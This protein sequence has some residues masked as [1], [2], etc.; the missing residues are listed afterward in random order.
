MAYNDIPL[1]LRTFKQWVC[2]RYEEGDGGKPTK[3][4]YCAYNGRLAATDNP[5][6]WCTFDEAVYAQHQGWYAGIG[7]VLTDADP[8]TFI[9]LDDP[10]EKNSK[11]EFKHANPDEVLQRQI[12]LFN[13][14]KSYA[15]RSPSGTGLHIICKGRVPSG[16]RRS[17]IEVYSNLRFMTMTGDVYRN[18][19]I[20]DE[21]ELV[22]VLYN[23]MGEGRNAVAFYA[24]L[25]HATMTDEA[26]IEM[27]SNAANGEKFYDLFYVGNW[28]KYYPSQSEADFA[29]FDII[30]FYSK[31]G[32]QTQRIFLNSAIGQREK[33]RAQYRLNY[34]L[35]RCFDNML[36]PVDVDGLRNQIEEILEKKKQE[37]IENPAPVANEYTPQEIKTEKSIYSVPPGLVGQ[38]AQFIYAQAPRPVAEI[39]LAGALGFVAGIVGRAY[40]VSGTGLN[41]YI[42]LLAP[43]GTGKEAIAG[44]IDK[45][46]AYVCKS[47]PAAKDFIGP[48]KI[49]SE[50]ALLKYLSRSSV[51]FSSVVGEFGIRIRE[52][53]AHNAAPHMA[54]LLALLLDLFN[55]SGEGKV[56]HSS[57]YSDR[58]K[59]TGDILAPAVSITGESTPEKFYEILNESMIE[60]GMLPRW[61]IIEY[62]GDRPP[63]NENHMYAQPSFE[64]IEKLS[65]LCAHCLTLNSQHKAIHVQ[66]TPEAK[67]LFERFDKHCDLNINS[68][69][70][71]V[72]RH[73]WNRA[74][75]NSL[76]LAALVSTGCNPY[77][78]TIDLDIGNWAIDLIVA[79]VR[80]MLSRFDAGEI[81]ID[82]EETKQLS[83]LMQ[84]IKE[85]IL[86]PWSEVEKYAS[87]M[88]NL[89]NEKVIPYSYL[90]RRLACVATFRK[91]RIGSSNA[92]KRAIK[93]LQERGDIQEV[94]R[95]TMTKQYNSSAVAY[96]I[97]NTKAFEL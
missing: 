77:D 26:V 24:G 31:N 64:L 91:D 34:M 18:A 60:S 93:T 65:T 59:N 66:L 75:I 83:K 81:G 97:S 61:N 51:S 10:F 9:D 54:N 96:M 52:M 23:Q 5:D 11:G 82:N 62:R 16:R 25:E 68:S 57:I 22:N 12:K 19:A 89:H 48:S 90:Q 46:M 58:E 69:D 20:Y 35:A 15:E 1:E 88:S 53:S 74:H 71:E 2:W 3:V 94:G 67:D 78:P 49:N 29:L 63:L 36:P 86:S 50:Q 30:A 27:A 37:K 6:T 14:T 45:L 70:R 56:V 76:K 17:A 73:L 84:T 79:N 72:R 8:F 21:N 47:V 41:Q 33:S 92:I 40:N 44:G 39:A 85:F 4:P 87:G 38:I 7:F 13:E 42:L 80:N 95:A 43:T 28:Q 55:K 32:K